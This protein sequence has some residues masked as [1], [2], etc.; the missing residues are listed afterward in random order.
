MNFRKIFELTEEILNDLPECFVTFRNDNLIDQELVNRARSFTIK[1]DRHP[2]KGIIK[3]YK[4]K[5]L[6]I[7]LSSMDNF[8]IKDLIT[9]VKD[10]L[11]DDHEKERR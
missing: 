8:T 4:K 1:I 2:G 6:P 10:K 11:F 5:F 7:E 9:E 3:T